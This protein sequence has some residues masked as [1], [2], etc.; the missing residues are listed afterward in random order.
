MTF[1]ASSSWSL[2]LGVAALALALPLPAAAAGEACLR[3]TE[4]VGAEL[5][6]GGTCTAA[7]VQACTSS[8]DCTRDGAE[9]MDGFCKVEGVACQNPA[10]ACWVVDGGGLCECGNGEG[11]G[12]A[13][14]F[15]PDDPPEPQ[16]D[17]DL[18]ATCQSA[19]VDAC[20]EDPP[21]LP[22]SCT[23]DVLEECQALVDHE[24]ALFAACGEDVNP[25]DLARVGQCCD[26]YDDAMY[27]DYRECTIALPTDACPGDAWSECEGVS[28]GT[29]AGGEGTEDQAGAGESDQ[30]LADRGCT[31]ASTR[32][33]RG[34]TWL[35][36]FA[37]LAALGT[38]RRRRR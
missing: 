17:D 37:M 35:A 30:D 26:Q 27:A 21:S 12:W 18:L 2:P 6:L 25:I 1:F 24:D 4:C 28:G 8:D 23:G 20:G 16:T 5:C 33:A 38:T 10:G 22:E 7:D 11:S 19:L 34:A 15:N 9:C 36:A 31:I 3:D 32:D 29:P 14:G 13:D